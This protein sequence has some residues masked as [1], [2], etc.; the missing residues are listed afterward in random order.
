[1]SG[2]PRRKWMLS[3]ARYGLC[4]AAIAW[5]VHNVPW[6]DRVRL[7]GADG[8]QVRLIAQHTDTVDIERDG[9][10]S[11]IPLAGVHH[12]VVGGQSIPDIEFG[13]PSVVRRVDQRLALLAVLIFGPAWFI[14]SWRLVLMVGIQGLKLS[15]WSAVKLTFVG[16]FF[17]FALPGT[18]GGDLVKA[19]YITQYTHRKTEVVTTIFLDRAIGLLGMVLLAAAGILL[20][21]DPEE[22]GYLLIVLGVVFGGLLI[23][24]I[25]IFSKRLRHALRLPQ[26]GERLPMGAQILRIGRATI[27]MRQHKARVIASMALTLVLQSIVMLSAAMMAWALGMHG[28]LLYFVVYVAIGF[29]ISSVPIS[30]PQAIG[31]ME[32]AYVQFFT[33]GEM[34]TASQAV[35]LALAVRLIQLVW[36]LPGVLVPLLGAHRPSKEDLV[37]IERAATADASG[38]AGA[39]CDV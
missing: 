2:K 21:W 27:A 30:P 36:A 5:L 24:A 35:A 3:V 9:R 8:P 16:N 19:Y 33:L 14:Q 26:L 13:M 25:L 12:V 34:N 37:A 15:Y 23:G 18:T 22:F 38:A 39:A 29:L 11:T 10:R 4:V 6:H 31:V 32:A 28:E 17:N 20:L 1:M 7:D